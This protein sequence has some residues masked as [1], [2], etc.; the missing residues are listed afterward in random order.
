MTIKEL[1]YKANQIMDAE[2]NTNTCNKEC[3]YYENE[4]CDKAEKL[5]RL[6]RRQDLEREKNN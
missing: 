2:C 6:F 1:I 5:K 4:V 3:K